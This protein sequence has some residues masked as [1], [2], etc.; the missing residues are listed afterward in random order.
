MVNKAR[1]VLKLV[2]NLQQMH[3]ILLQGRKTVEATGDLITKEEM[4]NSITAL[5]TDNYR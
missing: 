2:N 4:E 3:L 5:F 1:N